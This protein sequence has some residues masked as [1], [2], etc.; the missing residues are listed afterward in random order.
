MS[1][2]SQLTFITESLPEF[3]VGQ[4]Y[5]EWLQVS[6]GT[7]PYSFAVTQGTVPAGI[8]VT[9]MGTVNG[10]PL[11]AEDVTFEVTVTD[12]AGANET[13]AFEAVVVPQPS[14]N[15]AGG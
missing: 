4:E 15:A 5:T 11:Q 14:S 8:E 7:P 2:E 13:Q 12:S 6:G 1:T 9:S 10:V 3:E